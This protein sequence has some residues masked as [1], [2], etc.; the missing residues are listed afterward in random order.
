MDYSGQDS[1]SLTQ[2]GL[3]Y[4]GYRCDCYVISILFT[5]ISNS[6]FVILPNKN[7]S[8]PSYGKNI[9]HFAFIICDPVFS[10]IV[11]FWTNTS[12]CSLVY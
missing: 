4:P 10:F 1:S 3:N 7:T 9:L 11:V 8:R 5:P 12:C 2:E 6:T